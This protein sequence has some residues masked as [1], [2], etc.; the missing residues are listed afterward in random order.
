MNNIKI[1]NNNYSIQY[2]YK[3]EETIITAEFNKFTKEFSFNC[4]Q[5][6]LL[7]NFKDYIIDSCIKILIGPKFIAQEKDEIWY[8]INRPS[9]EKKYFFSHDVENIEYKNQNIIMEIIFL[10]L[11]DCRKL[12]YIQ[13]DTDKDIRRIISENIKQ[14]W[15]PYPG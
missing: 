12:K 8:K 10:I 15:Y 5:Y 13:F 7:N 4:T 9:L 2:Y 11:G 1:I 14:D 3:T 6:N